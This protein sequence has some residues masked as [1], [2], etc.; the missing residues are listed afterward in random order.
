MEAIRKCIEKVSKI[1]VL[2][3]KTKKIN[4]NGTVG[5]RFCG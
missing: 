1:S 5:I 2:E 3:V 4:L